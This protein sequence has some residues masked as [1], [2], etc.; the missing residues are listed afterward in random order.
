[1]DFPTLL[2]GSDVKTNILLSAC[3]EVE[4]TFA[5]LRNH[6]LRTDKVHT[7]G[8][9]K[10]SPIKILRKEHTIFRANYRGTSFLNITYKV[11]SIVLCDSLN[12]TANVLLGSVALD[13]VEDLLLTKYSPNI[14]L[15]KVQFTLPETQSELS[16]SARPRLQTRRLL[17][18][19]TAELNKEGIIA[20]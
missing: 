18:F 12:S 11:T 8:R 14:K 17:Q 6:K 1:M 2:N 19:K 10:E 4:A 9:T 13:L 5:S 15:L 16:R 7:N 3:E 20:F